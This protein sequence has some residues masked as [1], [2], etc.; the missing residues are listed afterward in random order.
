MLFFA[1]V[2]A[3]ALGEGAP[4]ELVALPLVTSAATQL[5]DA[6]GLPFASTAAGDP[7]EIMRTGDP[8]DRYWS[9]KFA[10]PG[11]NDAIRADAKDSAGNI[12]VGGQFTEIGGVAASHIAKW[13]GS[14]WSPLGSGMNSA[15]DSLVITGN[16]LFAGGNFTGAGNKSS[17]YLAL[18]QPRV[19]IGARSFSAS[20]GALTL[21]NDPLGF[22]KPALITTAGSTVSYG[23]GLP[24][25]VTLNQAQEINFDGARVNGA[26][27]LSPA[28]MTFGGAGAT[29]RV[30]FSEDDVAAYPGALYTD[31]RAARL[32]YPANYPASKKALTVTL[33]PGDGAPV[34]VRQENGRQ[35]DAITVPVSYTSAADTCFGAVPFQCASLRSPWNEYADSGCLHPRGSLP[36]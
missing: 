28:G 3:L 26:F 32:T 20:S 19:N 14:A 29:L 5:A 11:A 27:T 22:Y 24:V 25:T 30:E 13:D 31:F 33:R 10:Y 9:D 4:D 35:I 7:L 2:N 12:Y 6:A 18:W 16:A 15:V 36:M 17:A 23:P 21:G 34:P 1:L 8:D